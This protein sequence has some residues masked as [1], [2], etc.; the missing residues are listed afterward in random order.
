M[1]AACAGAGQQRKS[2]P[3]R[4]EARR[5]AASPPA[6]R[7]RHFPSCWMITNWTRRFSWRPLAVSFEARGELEP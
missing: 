2:P 1:V 3:D 5:G 4:G 6:E 7:G